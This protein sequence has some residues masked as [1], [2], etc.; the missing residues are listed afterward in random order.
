MSKL[1]TGLDSLLSVPARLDGDRLVYDNVPDCSVLTCGCLVS[2]SFA[3]CLSQDG[4]LDCPTCKRAGIEILAPVEPLREL[5]LRMHALRLGGPDDSLAS[6]D[7]VSEASEE[8]KRQEKQDKTRRRSSSKK[9][10]GTALSNS[11]QQPVRPKPKTATSKVSLLAAFHEV[12]T[13]VNNDA[14]VKEAERVKPSFRKSTD[15]GVGFV[16]EGN[17][18]EEWITT[19]KDYGPQPDRKDSTGIDPIQ[20]SQ[21]P[22]PELVVSDPISIPRKSRTSFSSMGRASNLTKALH[23]STSSTSPIDGIFNNSA[24]SKPK[25]KEANKEL[26]YAKNF[27]F[28]RKLY[29]Y[30]THQS[31]FFLRSRS[32]KLFINTGISPNLRRFVLLDEKRWEVYRIDPLRPEDP[33]LL[34]SCGKDTGAY[35][36]TFEEL[37]PKP[38]T[39]EVYAN[40]NSD[41]TTHKDLLERL[42]KWEHLCCKISNNLLVIAGTRGILR[43]FDLNDHGKPLYT[44][45]SK[46]PIRCIDISG[47]ERFIS[48]GVTG[49]DKFSGFEQPFI[50]LLRLRFGGPNDNDEMEESLYEGLLRNQGAGSGS[51]GFSVTPLTVTLPYRDPINILQFSPN[52]QYLSC[53]T[54][55]ESR[56][57]IISIVEPT[58]PSL[59]MKSQ[60]K[61]D[62]S[63][64]SEGI[65]D[66]QFFP[67]NRLMTLTSV[68]FNSCP[69]IIDTKTSSITGLEGV[70][71]PVMLVRV[72][73]VGSTIHK[74]AVSPRGDSVAYLDRSGI[75]YLMASPR[76]DDNDNKRIVVVT[77]AANSY[78]VRESASMRFDEDGYKLY[79]LDRKGVLQ[80]AD[81]TAGSREDHS[82]SRTK[83]IN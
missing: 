6:E 47:N 46:F 81:F 51:E 8:V 45:Y 4:H 28:Y 17:N 76:M 58:R 83:I 60:R 57:M 15:T 79:I 24:S 12:F 40:S 16:N 64:E 65:T 50:V 74:S 72:D 21:G 9:S 10:T 80:I 11:R 63:L 1:I 37:L 13:E 41:P 29:Q 78:R 44:Y 3:V 68:A 22:E 25:T 66:I 52:S 23:N 31:K 19:I 56:F 39:E 42:N 14:A 34:E 2:E 49:K 70:A 5:Y 27:P 48:L 33:P 43:I 55:M 67:D 30:H 75:C 61:L 59:I 32:S 69:I 18:V 62:T 38:T 26:L 7:A 20:I 35:G 54:A 77:E 36:A 71:Q 82:I 53:A 73:E